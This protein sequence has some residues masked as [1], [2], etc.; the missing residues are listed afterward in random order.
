MTNGTKSADIKVIKN[1]LRVKQISQAHDD[2]LSN[3]W[4]KLES[5]KKFSQRYY[6]H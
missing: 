3:Y 5:N 4:L 1:N 6:C 2:H